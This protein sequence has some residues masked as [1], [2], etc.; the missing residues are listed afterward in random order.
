MP[1][2]RARGYADS[3]S[4]ASVAAGGT[5]GVL[6]PPSIVLILYAIMTMNSIGALFAAAFV[7]GLLATLL[8]MA[9][10]VVQVRR[11]PELA[12]AGDR[13]SGPARRRA[14]LGTWDA[15]LLIVVV[16]GGIYGKVFSPSEAAAV[17][18]AGALL[19]TIARGRFDA[20]VVRA[21]VAETAGMVGMIFLILMG[22]SIFNYFVELSGL[23]DVL[24]GGIRDAGMPPLA[25]LAM[26]IVFYI[27]LGCFMDSLSMVL[28]TVVPMYTLVTGIGYDPI[29]FGILL[30]CVTEIGL[31]TPPIGMN[32]F[33]VQGT[34]PNLALT[35]II[36][37]IA[38][39]I[40]ADMVRVAVIVALPGLVLFLPRWL[41]LG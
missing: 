15:L 11:R 4:S 9:A 31:I 10:I 27:V 23:T 29:W 24:L 13:A 20:A 6:I 17:G 18:A 28:L 1:E 36:R 38:P 21:G 16:I 30:V 3:L 7:P 33:V 40:L 19:I 32:L 37:G 35:T 5:L 41:G 39:F 26:V 8:Y 34:V 12:P 2:M 25:V 14:L 22:A